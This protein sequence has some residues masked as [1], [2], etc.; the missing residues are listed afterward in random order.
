MKRYS[1]LVVITTAVCTASFGCAKHDD[2]PRKAAEAFAQAADECLLDVRN[3]RNPWD[4]SPNCSKLSELNHAYIS[5]G[6]F[7]DEPAEVRLVAQSALTTAWK[8]RAVSAAGSSISL[9]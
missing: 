8:A 7:D 3:G 2:Q 1:V 6:G 5:A 9:W 4:S